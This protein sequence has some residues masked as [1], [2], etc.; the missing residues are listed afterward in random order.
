[1]PQQRQ[2]EIDLGLNTSNFDELKKSA[3]HSKRLAELEGCFADE[4][5][6]FLDVAFPPSKNFYDDTLK[7]AVANLYQVD[8]ESYGYDKNMTL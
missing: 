8:F 6:T 3:H 5:F 7:K 1:M 4:H 2:I